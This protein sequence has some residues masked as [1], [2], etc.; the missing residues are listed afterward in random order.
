MARKSERIKNKEASVLFRLIFLPISIVFFVWWLHSGNGILFAFGFIFAFFSLHLLV[1]C[2]LVRI[3][4]LP[5]GKNLLIL[6]SESPIWSGYFQHNVIEKYEDKAHILNWSER[7]AWKKFSI[8]VW[9]FNSFLGTQEHTPSV[10]LFSPWYQP[11]IF[12]FWRPFKEFKHG[13]PNDVETM[14][15]SL[16]GIQQL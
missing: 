10:I 9:L 4:W 12:R 1:L 2:T 7:K 16:S 15:R 6:T 14:L 3:F 13:K 11:K 8:L 5:K